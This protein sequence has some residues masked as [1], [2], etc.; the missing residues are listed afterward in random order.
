MKILTI[1]IRVIVILIVIVVVTITMLFFALLD[2]E[3]IE[4]G[5]SSSDNTYTG[6]SNDSF[7]FPVTRG[8]YTSSYG[9][10]YDPISGLTSKHYG[11]DFAYSGSDEVILSFA[12]GIVQESGYGPGTGYYVKIYHEVDGEKYTARYLHFAYAS[13]LKVGDVVQTGQQIGVMGTTGYSTGIHL[14]FELSYGHNKSYSSHLANT[15]NPNLLF[16]LESGVYY[17]F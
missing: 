3:N 12:N 6:N 11:M 17:E 13:D 10:R 2:Y 7:V 5:S 8:Y 16:K 1:K 4:S 9:S 15:F 14:H